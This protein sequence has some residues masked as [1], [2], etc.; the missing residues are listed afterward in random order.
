[1]SAK[2][3]YRLRD[4]VVEEVSLVDA[5]ANGEADVVIFK[6]NMK[7]ADVGDFEAAR[8]AYTEA[9]KAKLVQM[10]ELAKTP[11]ELRMAIDACVSEM[12]K[13]A[14]GM[15]PECG[16]VMKDEMCP[17]CGYELHKEKK[18]MSD[19]AKLQAEK[20]AAEAARKEAEG[21][22]ASLTAEIDGLKKR[23]DAFENTPEAIEKRKLD[24]LPAEIRKRLEDAEAQIKT[25]Q[26]ATAVAEAVAKVSK[27]DKLPIK[28][29]DF[30][31]IYKRLTD[32]RTAEDVAKLDEILAAAN[33]ALALGFTEI[34]KGGDQKATD[35]EAEV[36]KRVSKL[37]E[38]DPKL[39]AGDAMAKV[40]EA[41][42]GLYERYRAEAVTH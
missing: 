36:V 38:A 21:K 8:L 33:G 11:G 26:D 18:D 7:K 42:R 15:C 31:P 2:K 3:Q 23:L 14:D 28:A 22:V 25:A 6:R 16:A 40:F 1:M 30:G 34:G 39:S 24:A 9:L 12:Y 35:A 41:D 5:G 32:G 20:D 29:V 10:M 4:L 17:E 27:L 37:R 19:T 13:A